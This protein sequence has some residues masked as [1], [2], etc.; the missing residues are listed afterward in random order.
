MQV[1]DTFYLL[2]LGDQGDASCFLLDDRATLTHRAAPPLARD[3][4]QPSEPDAVVIDVVGVASADAA[5]A[6][7]LLL[8]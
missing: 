5:A 1:P 7:E 6:W 3:H 4:A 2:A 8:Y